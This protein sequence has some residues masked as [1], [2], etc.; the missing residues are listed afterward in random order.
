[1][2]VPAPPAGPTG[3][4][5]NT[6]HLTI[7]RKAQYSQG[8]GYAGVV[9]LWGR[10]I[11][12]IPILIVLYLVGIVAFFMAWFAQFSVVSTGEYPQN[13]FDFVRRYLAWMVRTQAFVFGLTDKYPS[14][15]DDD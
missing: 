10:A 9:L 1:M 11:C 7:D 13:N 6:V 5:V 4:M 2:T 12:A 15:M 14:Q 3:S 8:W